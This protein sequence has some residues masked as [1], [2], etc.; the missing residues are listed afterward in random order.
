M[1]ANKRFIAKKE[2]SVR[3]MLTILS[4]ALSLPELFEDAKNRNVEFQ[5]FKGGHLEPHMGEGT[6]FSDLFALKT[7]PHYEEVKKM[8]FQLTPD[9]MIKAIESVPPKDV[10]EAFDKMLSRVP[11]EQRVRTIDMILPHRR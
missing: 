8:I 5:F 11:G 9:D 10:P 4:E 1:E 7:N 3:E 2:I 6:E